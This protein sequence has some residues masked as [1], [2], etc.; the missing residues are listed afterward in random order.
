MTVEQLIEMLKT[1]PQNLKIEVSVDMSTNEDDC[2]N[3]VFGKVYSVQNDGSFIT[4]LAESGN[5]NY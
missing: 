4:I 2:G 3:R 1:F 5:S